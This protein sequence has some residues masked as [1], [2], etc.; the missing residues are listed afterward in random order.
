MGLLMPSFVQQQSEQVMARS[1][2]DE[3]LDP[4]GK[5]K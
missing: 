5:M 1:Q 3:L 2:G 4:S